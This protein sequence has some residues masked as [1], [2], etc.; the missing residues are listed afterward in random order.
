MGSQ[1]RSTVHL[2]TAAHEPA[3]TQ[4]WRPTPAAPTLQQSVQVHAHKDFGGVQPR[5]VLPRQ[6]TCHLCRRTRRRRRQQ[7]GRRRQHEQR[8]VADAPAR[9]TSRRHAACS[10]ACSCG[11]SAERANSSGAKMAACKGG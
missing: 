2:A 9:S 4:Q 5:L 11:C 6:R 8:R 3:C 1:E 10:A 7:R